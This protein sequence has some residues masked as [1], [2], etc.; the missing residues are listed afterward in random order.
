MVRVLFQLP[1]YTGIPVSTNLSSHDQLQ[2]LQGQRQ[3]QQQNRRYALILIVKTNASISHAQP[4]NATNAGS[5]KNTLTHRKKSK[6]PRMLQ[7]I[8][9]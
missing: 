4:V 5:W 2:S 1:K 6:Q 3:Q 9:G 7:F 8:A